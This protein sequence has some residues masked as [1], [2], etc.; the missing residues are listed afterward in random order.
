[1]AKWLTGTKAFNYLGIGLA[2]IYLNRVDKKRFPILNNK[3]ADSLALFNIALSS[4]I[5]KRYKTVL[6]SQQQ[7]IDWFPQFDNFYR[8]DALNQFLIGEEE[9][10]LWQKQLSNDAG[11]VPDLR[12]WIFQNNPKYYD[13]IGALRDGALKTWSVNQHKKE[14]KTGDR[15]IIWITGENS[16]CYGIATVMSNVQPFEEDAKEA[17][18]RV[19]PIEKDVS[20]G[21][22]IRIDNNL[23]NAPVLKEELDKLPEFSDFPAG[24]QGTNL[25]IKE[26]HFKGIQDLILGRRQ[27]RYWVYAPGPNAKFWDECWEKGII[28]YGA[29]EL[30]DLQAY[31]SKGAIEKAIKKA[32]K[33]KNRPTNDA[34][35]AWE[36][37]RVVKP[38]DVIIAKK[39]RTQYIGY[40]VVA[41]P[42]G[43]DASRSTY[44]NVRTMKWVKKGNWIE[45]KGPIVLKTLTDITKYP[46]YVEKLKKLIGIEDHDSNPP[47]LM[48]ALNTILYGPPGTG[49]TYTLQKKYMEL[50][51]ESQ[52]IT[53]EQFAQEMVA[54]MTW[55]Q[56]ITI[57]LY[58][59]KAAKVSEIFAHPLLQTKN[60]LSANKTPKNTIWAWLQRHTKIDCPNVKHSQRDEPLIFWKDENATWSVDQVMVDEQLPELAEKLK[61][62]LEF[63]PVKKDIKRYD[64]VTFHQSYCYEDFIEG[65][66]P[67]MSEED[68][69]ALAY[70]I[71]P[72]IF[73]NMVTMALNDPSHNYALLIDEINRGNVAS[74]F[75]E[76]IALIEEDKRKGRVNELKARLPYSR[77][78]FAVPDNLYIIGA[79][80][81]ADR[82]VEALDTALRRR[83]TFEALY[84]DPVLIKQPSDFAV[85][86]QKLLSTIN[87][88]IEKLLDKDHCIGHSYFMGI[89]KKDTPLEEL[90]LIFKTKVLPLLEEYFFGDPGKI[91]MV[92]GKAFVARKDETIQWA[93]GDWGMD[94]Y[95][96]RRV[97]ALAD[98]M[99]LTLEDFQSVYEG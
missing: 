56:V 46:D 21:V 77:E 15:V 43:Y 58:K 42:Y 38:G 55:L 27:M 19:T 39:G 59:L 63:K 26:S 92:L 44:R 40:G 49:K 34:R 91:G 60:R 18:Y 52:T 69:S 57:I 16:G 22:M 8:A 7:L 50:F 64:Y 87:G 5:V 54:E 24:T 47:R 71:K 30:E 2:T 83:F 74:I 23:W 76:L 73:R 35:A 3:T 66:K 88:R 67:I 81:T 28:V 10:K 33:L 14:M 17:S 31:E 79:M 45:T 48:P 85:D 75:G 9:G 97:Y 6:D 32:L 41:G 62:Y 94:D 37:S 98:P 11:S 36:F 82:S 68:A 29:D 53:Q 1:M 96:E 95:E 51:T 70:E 86:L 13:V 25:K 20:E 4:D 78:E 99:T 93:L 80:N 12:Y 65:I 90:R 61:M 89:E 84:P 72:G